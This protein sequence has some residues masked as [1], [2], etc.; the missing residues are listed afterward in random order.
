MAEGMDGALGIGAES[1]VRDEEARPTCRSRRRRHRASPRRCRRPTPDCR[2]RRPPRPGASACPRPWQLRA[3]GGRSPRCPH[4]ASASGRGACRLHRARLAT[5]CAPRCRARRCRMS[6]TCRRHI[7]RS[8]GSAHSPLASSTFATLAK[9]RGSCFFTQTSFG[10]VKPAMRDIAGDVAASGLALLDLLAF[11]EGARVVPQDRRAQDLAGL[12][13]QCRA[14]LLAG[15]ADAF[16]GGDLLRLLALDAPAP[17][18]SRPS[19]NVRDP[20]RTSRDGAA[21]RSEAQSWSR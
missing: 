19:T 12:V 5:I 4:R 11:G 15:K 3:S 18:W 21:T 17:P 6:P 7:R 20:A 9:T 8:C 16:D 2:R 10:A 14:M 1:L 13:E